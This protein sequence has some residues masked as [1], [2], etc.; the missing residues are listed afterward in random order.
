HLAYPPPRAVRRIGQRPGE[1]VGRKVPPPGAGRPVTCHSDKPPLAN[2]L[3]ALQPPSCCQAA[4]V[5]MERRAYGQPGRVLKYSYSGW[6]LIQRRF[7]RILC[8]AQQAICRRRQHGRATIHF[9]LVLDLVRYVIPRIEVQNVRS[10]L[11]K[12]LEDHRR[13]ALA[14]GFRKS[15]VWTI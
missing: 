4:K 15:V 5:N 3:G 11:Q 7:Y 10:L 13:A 2:W 14:D 9:S 6:I 12:V 8:R 1:F